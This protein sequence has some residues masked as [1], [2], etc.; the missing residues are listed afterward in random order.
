MPAISRLV[1]A[2]E[3][4][5]NE[6]AEISATADLAIGRIDQNLEYIETWSLW[7]DIKIIVRT[8]K[9]EILSGSGD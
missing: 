1:T 9:R 6:A 5:I 4:T 3:P 2:I 8:I 7:L